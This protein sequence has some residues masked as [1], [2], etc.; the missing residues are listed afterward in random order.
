MTSI[1]D[2][3]FEKPAPTLPLTRKERD[4]FEAALRRRPNIWALMG[5]H[6]SAGAA[7]QAAYSIRRGR[8]ARAFQPAG[9]FE[10]DAVTVM[11]EHRIYAR[12][13]GGAASEVGAR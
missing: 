9:A 2:V 10:A 6:G 7:R 5:Q 8:Y 11:G 4:T 13:T 3:R 1:Y 12:Y